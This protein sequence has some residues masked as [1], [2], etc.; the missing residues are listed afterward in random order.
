MDRRQR[1][2]QKR[3]QKRQ[4][5][6][7]RRQ[8]FLAQARAPLE[9]PLIPPKE[10]PRP[11]EIKVSTQPKLDVKP[12]KPPPAPRRSTSFTQ[13]SNKPASTVTLTT[14]PSPASSISLSQSLATPRKRQRLEFVDS[15]SSSSS[16]EDLVAVFRRK[17]AQKLQTKSHTQEGEKSTWDDRIQENQ[18]TTPVQKS[19][20]EKTVDSIGSNQSNSKPVEEE[21]SPAGKSGRTPRNPLAR[22][23]AAA[24]SPEKVVA[25]H[26]TGDSLWDDSDDDNNKSP[27]R[28][29]SP[30]RKKQIRKKKE[31]W[32]SRE[33]RESISQPVAKDPTERYPDFLAPKFG[34]FE[35]EPLL[36]GPAQ[37]TKRHQVPASINRFLPTYQKDGISFVYQQAI[38]QR[39]GAIL[40][41]GKWVGESLCLLVMW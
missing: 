33:E 34:P 6:E 12:T 14:K 7:E 24:A 15:D 39:R 30:E 22:M 29:E 21:V 17:K 25:C 5:E 36:L 10:P 13:S 38:V 35:D 40:G 19:A 2:R 1:E 31:S 8:R 41:D 28:E 4:R 32:A 3:E 18:N 23:A 11:E 27:S 9:T 20:S 26:P 16:D 37:V